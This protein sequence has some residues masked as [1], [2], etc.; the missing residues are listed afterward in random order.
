MATKATPAKLK[1]PGHPA[2]TTEDVRQGSD[3]VKNGW[4]SELEGRIFQF[5]GLADAFIDQ[6]LPQPDPDHNSTSFPAVDGEEEE[7]LDAL[8]NKYNPEKGQE[9]R[10]Y[11]A[12]VSGYLRYVTTASC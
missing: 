4:K 3:A 11:P 6:L 7:K 12:L 9:V 2:N 10:E 5:P 1:G 8:F